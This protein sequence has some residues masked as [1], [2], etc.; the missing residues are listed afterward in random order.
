[1]GEA[2]ANEGLLFQKITQSFQLD[3]FSVQQLSIRADAGGRL[4][5][6]VIADGQ[7]YSLL[8]RPN[9]IRAPG[10]RVLVDDGAGWLKE[11]NP[12]PS[13]TYRGTVDG[14]PG[15]VVAASFDDGQLSAVIRFGNGDIWAIQPVTDA[16]PL[17]PRSLHVVFLDADADV[18]QWACGSR[19]HRAVHGV[20]ALPEG[21]YSTV[22]GPPPVVVADLALD[23][24]FEFLQANGGSV[25]ATVADIEFIVNAV[26]VIYEND[27]SIWHRIT[28][29]LARQSE[30]D[31]YTMTDS[32]L[33]LDEFIAE[34]NANQTTV[35]RDVAHLMTGK[36]LDTNIIGIAE[37]QSV[38]TSD[39]AYGLRSRGSVPRCRL[40]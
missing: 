40:A 2:G 15:S 25:D 38:C 23:A 18:G 20:G 33:L 29:V 26:N 35:L 32:N 28:V 34:W 4:S 22:A 1:M 27:V 39:R 5:T 30:P 12:P 21:D 36:D 8:L 3:R 10:F 7:R 17:A 24:D 13:K 16:V 37:V 19:N 6:S 14:S 11:A 9:I 31:P